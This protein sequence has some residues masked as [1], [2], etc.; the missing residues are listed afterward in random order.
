MN[1]KFTNF[2]RYTLLFI[3]I[4]VISTSILLTSCKDNSNDGTIGI[5]V[6]NSYGPMPVARGS[7]L[8]FIG[9]NLDKVTAISLPG[10]IEILAAA[11][12]TKTA[13]LVTI[14][15]PQDAVEGLV[16]VK[17]P[18]GDI[19]TKTPIGFSEPISIASFTPDPI[20]AGQELTITGDYLNLVKEV[21]FTDR[22][23]VGSAAFVS[24]TRTQLK[25]IVPAAA[26]TGKISVSD[27]KEDPIIVYS[28]ALLNV[29]L[30]V[31]TTFLPN[32]VKAGT[33]LTITGT[34]L[35]LIKTVALGGSQNV[36]SFVSQTGTQLV[37]KIPNLTKD[38]TLRIIPASGVKVKTLTKLVLVVPTVT[39]I[40]T[41]VK[42]GAIITV[43]GTDLDLV[44]VATFAGNVTGTISNQTAASMDITVPL[45]A[46]DGTVVF[47]TNSGKTVASAAITYI[48]PTITTIAPLALTAGEE[49]T[50]TGTDLDLVRKVTF[51]GGLSVD[52][53]P[54][55]ATSFNVA[56]PTAA[57]SGTITLETANGS[58]V[59]SADALA[60]TAANKPV[61]TGI[62]AVVKP[63]NKL[64]LTGTKLHLVESIYFAGNFK[65]VLYGIRS[66]T[67]IEVYVPL[68][69]SSGQT[70]ITLN[71][72][73]GAVVVSPVFTIAG[74]DPITAG[75]KMI[76]DF[77]IRSA[78][79][80]HAVDWDN[81]GGSYDAATSK[82]NGY[83]TLVAR[84]GW[85]ILGCNHPDP[86][87]GWPSVDP[88]KYVMKID[89]KVA[90]PILITGGYEFIIRIG[91]QDVKT[92][93]MV[94]GNY[95]AT[96]NNDWATLT[97]PISGILSNPTKS[98][99]DFGIILSYSD[100]GTNFA[101]LSFDNLRY[102]PK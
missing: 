71:A 19:T 55:S 83:I 34:D 65:A 40:P 86:N 51:G 24:Q 56:V 67:T 29:K 93:L 54:A 92:Q 17:T 90:K 76:Y 99:G 3:L 45:K 9:N 49:I 20:K 23:S 8:R 7:E 94:D 27:G 53:T 12:V 43:K 66:E 48:K 6:L 15:V 80:W 50:I 84:P 47:S 88:T 25:V 62:T 31:I 85:W 42:N 70:T 18:Q 35:D 97:I 98:S 91:G 52:I 30:P 61:V 1:T 14:T 68:T 21:I 63:G 57:T 44:T 39:E 5:V 74:T 46:T 11:F 75:T 32:P 95:I 81:W 60:V 64:T 2:I 78:S 100:G 73:D 87:G 38:D 89:I 26:Q 72:F 16:V 69:A 101:G 79:D 58:K 13:T 82:A 59:V 37:L 4:G 28:T 41:S 36:T 22:V 102:D 96:P 33:N 77:N 10:G